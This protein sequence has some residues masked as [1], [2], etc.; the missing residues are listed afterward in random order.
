MANMP[1]FRFYSEALTD[2]KIK[3]VCQRTGVP[4]ALVLGV[5]A[6]FLSLANES[7]ERGKLMFSEGM[8]LTEEEVLAETGLDIVTF[9]KIVREFHALNMISFTAGY[10]I[11]NWDNR[12]FD[13]D[14]STARV[15]RYRA[16]K[17]AQKAQKQEEHPHQ[18]IKQIN[19]KTAETLVKRFSNVI[20]TDPDTKTETDS[21]VRGSELFGRKNVTEDQ[22]KAIWSGIVD[23]MEVFSERSGVPIPDLFQSTDFTK[24]KWVLPANQ[25]MLLM[26]DN[27]EEAVWLVN[28]TMDYFEKNGLT[29]A[30]PGSLVNVA[31]TLKDKRGSRQL[32]ALWEQVLLW[33]QG[34]MTLDEIGVPQVKPAINK[35][36]EREIKGPNPEKYK[37]QFIEF[38]QGAGVEQ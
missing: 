11:V 26:G 38:M 9:N 4:K 36:G 24:T 12:Q 28:T 30:N 23:V 13:S 3:R 22:Q 35:I 21:E 19:L 33:A 17:R 16:R 31:R 37:A 14:N 25:I 15:R 2:R 34:R 7:P 6:V 8:W 18:E 5:W 10:E 20:E 29:Y 32:D 1:W 27:P